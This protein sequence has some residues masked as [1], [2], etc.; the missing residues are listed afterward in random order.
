MGD[1]I[2]EAE[3]A[4]IGDNVHENHGMMPRILLV[5]DEPNVIEALKR[6]LRKERY[7]ILSAAS[8]DEAMAVLG[9]EHVDVVIADEMM[10]GM[11]GS[12]LLTLVCRLYPD[13]MRIILTGHAN[14]ES[15]L[16]AINAGQI[17]RYLTKPCN[18][19][20]LKV[21]LRQALQHRELTIASRE[22]LKKAKRQH[23]LLQQLESEHPGITVLQRDS[24]GTILI[25][26]SDT[27]LDL[28]A[29]IKEMRA[30]SEEV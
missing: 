22:L 17:Y 21:T 11:L 19:L 28:D 14:L 16:R 27:D 24:K 15:A 8:A 30:E 12:E 13:T 2:F 25:D 18:E 20:E 3:N 26:D 5:D 23:S 10:P 1:G 29:L 9:R 4:T 6:T 7:E